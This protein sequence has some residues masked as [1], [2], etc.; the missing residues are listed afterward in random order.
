MTLEE[1]IIEVKK[2]IVSK[3]LEKLY[4]LKEYLDDVHNGV[5]NG[6][7]VSDELYEELVR[8]LNCLANDVGTLGILP[9]PDMSS[10]DLSIAL[11]MGS[12]PKLQIIK[13]IPDA[14]LLPKFDGCSCGVRY[15]RNKESSQMELKFAK[16]RGTNT[17]RVKRCSDLTDKYRT[18]SETITGAFNKPIADTF[19]FNGKKFSNVTGISIRGEIVLKDKDV[20][21]GKDEPIVPAA[22]VAGKLNG[23]LINWNNYR[24]HLEYIP[25]EIVSITF[26]DN[27]NYVPTQYEVI[28][29]FQLLKIISHSVIYES[30]TESSLESVKDHFM[31]MRTETPQPLDGIVYCSKE[32]RYPTTEEATHPTNYG[33]YAWKPTS[34]ATSTVSGISWTIGKDGRIGFTIQYDPVRINGKNYSQTKGTLSYLETSLAGIG[35]GAIVTI[36]LA[37]D[38]NP[39]IQKIEEVPPNTVPFTVPNRCP[40]CGQPTEITHKSKGITVCTCTN[41][42]CKE[43]VI[44]KMCTFLRTIGV[45]GIADGKLRQLDTIDA[46]S[47][48]SLINK[49]ESLVSIIS[50]TTLADFMYAIG[51]GTKAEIKS[52]CGEHADSLI[53]RCKSLLPCIHNRMEDPFASTIIEYVIANVIDSDIKH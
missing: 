18:I 39:Q 48:A 7:I 34:S 3:D 50:R 31:T 19:V 37:G 2:A 6:P 5:I 15:E 8:V 43:V 38:I 51:Y 16:S 25:F 44:Q 47:V 36:I 29:F 13:D 33:K 10:K 21:F 35:V 27:S 4:P 24:E 9:S 23:D 46:I 52:A 11:W 42:R 22:F 30:L 28:Q 49:G 32:W 12:I 53:T 45:K 1:L 14:I 17:S 41:N 26:A 40:F 20:V